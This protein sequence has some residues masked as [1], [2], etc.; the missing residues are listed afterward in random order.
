M[1]ETGRECVFI[2]AFEHHF[3]LAC[4]P[5]RLVLPGSQDVNVNFLPVAKET[6]SKRA[7][8]SSP[9]GTA[10]TVK[11]S[12]CSMFSVLRKAGRVVQSDI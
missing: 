7:V 4:E 8:I 1:E 2:S 6:L 9:S 5:P 11:D 3:L 12:F 10:R